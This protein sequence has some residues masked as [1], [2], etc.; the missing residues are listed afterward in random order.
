MPA[1][2][3][4][5]LV[6]LIAAAATVGVSWLTVRVGKQKQEADAAETFTDIALSLITPLTE[7]ICVLEETVLEQ[8]KE[9]ELLKKENQILHRW[10]QLL[11]SQVVESG[12]EPISFEQVKKWEG[13]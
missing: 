3:I 4:P 5:V 12:V 8:T 7:R 11:F 13:D 10:S 6:S 2:V 1:Y 9:I